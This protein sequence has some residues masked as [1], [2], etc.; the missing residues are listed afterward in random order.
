MKD[1]IFFFVQVF[2]FVSCSSY[3]PQMHS[4]PSLSEKLPE[5]C[6]FVLSSITFLDLL[7]WK[8]LLLSIVSS[9]SMLRTSISFICTSISCLVSRKADRMSSFMCNFC[10]SFSYCHLMIR[11]TMIF[12]GTEE[13]F[14]LLWL[15]T[16]EAKLSLTVTINTC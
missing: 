2:L 11:L 7:A 12:T 6:F 16:N 8:C 10:F 9:L 1:L 15:H 3:C 13:S 4:I 5:S 14:L